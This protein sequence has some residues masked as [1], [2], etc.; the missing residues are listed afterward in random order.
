MKLELLGQPV[1]EALGVQQHDRL[2]DD[3]IQPLDVRQ[4]LR[5]HARQLGS[6]LDD[7]D[8]AA[9]RR[10]LRAKRGDDVRARLL[11]PVGARLDHSTGGERTDRH[12]G[13]KHQQFVIALRRRELDVGIL[14]R[15]DAGAERHGSRERKRK[16]PLTHLNPPGG[17]PCF[18][19]H[20]LSASISLNGS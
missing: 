11:G 20:L 3:E 5:A 14:P 17:R 12:V 10:L 15:L 19:P 4:L 18:P 6:A 9:P 8:L 13:P 16:T 2:G 7:L 1:V